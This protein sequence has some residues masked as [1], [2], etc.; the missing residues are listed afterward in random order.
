MPYPLYHH[1]QAY[2]GS[3]VVGT[4]VGKADKEGPDSPLRGYIAMLAVETEYRRH[5]I[6]EPEG[7]SACYAGALPCPAWLACLLA[8]SP[9]PRGDEEVRDR[10]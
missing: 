1:P 7:A 5:G 9:L 4:I 2:A 3:Q 10:L 8:L 6:G